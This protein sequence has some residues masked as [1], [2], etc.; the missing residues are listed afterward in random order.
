MPIMCN[1]PMR[2]DP[3]TI[4][5]PGGAT[6]TFDAVANPVTTDAD[7]IYT[8]VPPGAGVCFANGTKRD[9][10]R[11]RIS[12]AG[13]TIAH[14]ARFVRCAGAVVAA[15]EVRAEVS[16]AAVPQCSRTATLGV[17]APDDIF[18]FDFEAPAA[19]PPSTAKKTS[20]RRKSA[21]KSSSKRAKKRA[22]KPASKK[23]KRA[24]RKTARK[25]SRRKRPRPK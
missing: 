1:S 3:T 17:R 24:A 15:F 5:L 21:K 10:M 9:Q 20:T 19:A 18:S 11:Q 7:I 8:I 16:E 14:Q 2:A 13:T 23:P 6:L 25:A 12:A 4:S 22:K